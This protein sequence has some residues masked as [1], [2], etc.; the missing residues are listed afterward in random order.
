MTR[1]PAV[2]TP[3]QRLQN[4]AQ[5]NAA[6]LGGLVRV[7]AVIVQGKLSGYRLFPSGRGSS[8]TAFTQLGLRSG[9]LITA[10][11]GTALDD[12]NRAM[13][14][15]QTLSSASSAAITITRDGQPQE[16]NLNLE[17][18]ATQVENAASQTTTTERRGGGLGGPGAVRIPGGGSTAGNV[19][20]GNGGS[21]NTGGGANGSGS[22]AEAGEPPSQP[23]QAGPPAGNASGDSGASAERAAAER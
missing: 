21:G 4:L 5:N 11:N 2:P 17:T 10:V 15:L 20:A 14:I 18:V 8:A 3:A 7:Q 23:G 19:G 22:G 12:P 1:A 6:L 9:D 13:E 16:I